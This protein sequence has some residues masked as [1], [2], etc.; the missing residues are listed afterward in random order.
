MC[1]LVADISVHVHIVDVSYQ[2]GRGHQMILVASLQDGT[3]GQE[4]QLGISGGIYERL[5]L[6]CPYAALVS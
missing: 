4:G 3:A 1:V 2:S 6:E 5:C